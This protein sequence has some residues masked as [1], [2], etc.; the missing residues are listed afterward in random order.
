M[1]RIY[2]DANV[3]LRFLTGDPPEMA[4]AARALFEAVE[5]GEI[6][7]VIDEI[8]VAETVWVLKSFYGHLN[9][10]IARTL[11]EL[12]SHDGLEASDKP[13]LLTALTLFTEKNVD[14]ADALVAVHMQRQGIQ[15]IFSF[16]LHFDRIPGFT[17]RSP[18]AEKVVPQGQISL[19]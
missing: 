18:G 6:S 7:L 5:Q 12:L 13:G 3:I 19:A 16:D 2:I 8:V 15:E 10:E 9:Q 4:A 11:S 17:R 14:F 1:K